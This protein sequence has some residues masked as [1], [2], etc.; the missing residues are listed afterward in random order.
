MKKMRCFL[1]AAVSMGLTMTACRSE[2]EFPYDEPSVPENPQEEVVKLEDV[3]S[4]KTTD[5]V[6]FSL[7]YG[8]M[9]YMALVDIYIEKPETDENGIFINEP[10]TRAFADEQ[11]KVIFSDALPMWVNT[12]WAVNHNFG[13]PRVVELPIENGRV[14]YN[15]TAAASTRALTRTGETYTYE[16]AWQISNDL[17]SIVKWGDHGTP[18]NTFNPGVLMGLNPNVDANAVHNLQHMLWGGKS[19]KSSVDNRKYA[20]GSDKI[21]TTI[22]AEEYE[23]DGVI[24]KVESAT[25]SLTFLSE[26]AWNKNSIAYYYYPT[27]D[28][29]KNAND[30][31]KYKKYLIMPNASV[32]DMCPYCGNATHVTSNGHYADPKLAPLPE[33]SEFKLLYEDPETGE[34]SEN[35]PTG[36]TIGYMVI[37]SGYNLS[38]NNVS[39]TT[40]RYYSNEVANGSQQKRFIALKMADGSIVYGFEDGSDWSCE[41]GLFIISATPNEA[42]LTKDIPQIEED[43]DGWKVEIST[44]SQSTLAFEDQWPTGG[45]Y[46]L[47]D[48]IVEHTRVVTFNHADYVSE[49]K[50]VF[51]SVTPSNTSGYVNA[52]GF[53][54][55]S[56]VNSRATSVDYGNVKEIYND[57]NN[58]IS[59]IAFKHARQERGQSVTITRTFENKQLTR[60]QLNSY[61]PDLNEFVASQ[62]KDEDYESGQLKE[63]HIATGTPTVKSVKTDKTDGTQYYV[64]LSK[65]GKAFPFGIRLPIANWIYSPAG[66]RVDKTF[67]GYTEWVSDNTGKTKADWYLYPGK[68]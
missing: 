28:P 39:A 4:F 7:N 17:Y 21:N 13:V 38:I 25:I 33:L 36:L 11:G 51:K 56:R 43:V 58:K 62:Y 10:A 65:D 67:E 52:F 57:K 37:V 34:M 27:N 55:D 26:G 41:D 40:T 68:K 29:P 47:N 31:A 54:L 15:N 18:L 1:V 3:F 61:E 66:I 14:T 19:T 50:D 20:I 42:L 44:I 59:F 23:R 9:G 12:V 2:F 53:Q 63:I 32:P 6:N 46:D 16:K 45:D 8:N 5:K 48:V 60:T 49:V 30:M 24:H 64:D 35:F 22:V